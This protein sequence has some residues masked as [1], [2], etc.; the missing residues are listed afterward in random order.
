MLLYLADLRGNGDFYNQFIKLVSECEINH[1]TEMSRFWKAHRNPAV[2]FKEQWRNLFDP[3]TT[4]CLTHENCYKYQQKYEVEFV[5]IVLAQLRQINSGKGF[6]ASLNGFRDNKGKFKKGVIANHVIE[7]FQEFS[8]IKKMLSKAYDPK[9][10]N[11]IGHNEYKIV[12]DII[13]SIEGEY[14]ITGNQFFAS[15]L[16]LQEVHNATL[17][18]FSHDHIPNKKY[19]SYGVPS[20][21]FNLDM[22]LIKLPSLIV[23]QINTFRQIDFKATWLTE[24]VFSIKNGIITTSFSSAEKHQGEFTEELKGFINKAIDLGKINVSLI[25]IMP[26]VHKEDHAIRT[27]WGEFCQ[28]GSIHKIVV[29]VVVKGI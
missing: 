3:F 28:Y 6:D 2:K 1:P 15:Y 16:S 10:R 9:L 13:S 18:L 26:C 22:S 17:W 12:N 27:H 20:I 21:G 7:G 24:V 14:T 8:E 25:P 4:C 29:P 5:L 23:Y 11:I 19:A